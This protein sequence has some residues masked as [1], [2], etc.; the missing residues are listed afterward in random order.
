MPILFFKKRLSSQ[1]ARTASPQSVYKSQPAV[2]HAHAHTA[3]TPQ[4]PRGERGCEVG[5]NKGEGGGGVKR[6]GGL[7]G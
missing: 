5:G 3:S 2:L 1:L 6:E 7:L 4:S